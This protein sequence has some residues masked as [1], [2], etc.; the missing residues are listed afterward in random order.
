MNIKCHWIIFFLFQVPLNAR[1]LPTSVDT[2]LLGMTHPMDPSLSQI[3]AYNHHST[4]CNKI[5][6][7]IPHTTNFIKQFISVWHF[8]TTT[9]SPL[10]NAGYLHD[11]AT[12]KYMYLLIKYLAYRLCKPKALDRTFGVTWYLLLYR[13]CPGL[14]CGIN[15]VKPRFLFKTVGLWSYILP[16]YRYSHTL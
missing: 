15:I 10:T 5:Y 7:I 6:S 16:I 9:S 13:K 4:S 12:Y 3:C 8:L 14:T 2:V 1:Q 11:S